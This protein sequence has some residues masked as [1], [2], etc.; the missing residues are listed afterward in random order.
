MYLDYGF[1]DYLSKP[2]RGDKLE[3]KLLKY[4]PSEKVIKIGDDDEVIVP[5]E[6]VITHRLLNQQ[7]FK[8]S[9]GGSDSVTHIFI[10]NAFAGSHGFAG[11]LRRKLRYMDG[12]RYFIFNTREA[13]GEVKLVQEIFK[14]FGNEKLRFYCCGGSGTL[15][16]IINGIDDL[17]DVQ[18]AFY[19]CGLTNDFLKVFGDAAE[20]FNDI[21]N[22]IDGEILDVDYIK[23]SNG[24]AINT[25]STGL[26]SAVVDKMQDY[27]KFHMFYKH[28][29][30]TMASVYAIFF[31]KHENYDITVDG[32]RITGRM[33]EVYFGNGDTLGGTLHFAREANVRDGRGEYRIIHTAKR[34]KFMRMLLDIQ[35]RKYE[36][37]D[38]ASEFGRCREITIK[39]TDGSAFYVN[40]DGEL[41]GKRREWSARIVQ[42]GLHFVVPKGVVSEDE[43]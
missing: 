15:R 2:I 6:Q 25:F 31:A 22:L 23:T 10:V 9:P 19:P 33:G 43:E 20:K 16:N 5:K 40:Q 28:I 34:L 30:Y 11:D 36:V 42:R 35:K 29:P 3:N 18:I 24:V 17:S 14:I 4:L 7:V 12:L 13:G 1:D 39:K 37:I 26:D 32:R 21:E 8:T 27:R 41:I 38:G